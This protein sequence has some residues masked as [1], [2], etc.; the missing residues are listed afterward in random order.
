MYQQ[1]LLNEES[2]KL[3]TLNTHKGLFQCANL[4]FG[5]ASAPTVFQRMI[6]AILIAGHSPGTVLQ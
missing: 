6:D 2:Q 3:V 5:V 1:L 4:P